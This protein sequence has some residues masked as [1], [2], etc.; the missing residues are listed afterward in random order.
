MYQTES[1]VEAFIGRVTGA[2]RSAL[3]LDF[4]GTLAPF[5]D[6]RTRATPY[7]E[8]LPVLSAL[9]TN[10]RTRLV[11][12]S[13]RAARDVRE[14][15]PLSP[16]PEIWGAHGFERLL[17]DGTLLAAK[18]DRRS[19][20]AIVEA[21]RW[22][23]AQGFSDRLE[24]K[25]GGVA[26]HWRGLPA[27]EMENM[28]HQGMSAFL[29]LTR[30]T[31]LSVGEFDG[32]IELRMRSRSKGYAVQQIIHEMG[33][34]PIAYLGDDRTDEDAFRVL[35][36]VGLTVLV[37]QELRS[38]AAEIWIRPPEQLVEFL[39]SWLKASGGTQ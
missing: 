39:E 16:T 29:P 17:P 38:T 15:L 19:A 36:G 18:I 35:R 10:P 11:L 14:R 25:A 28:Y 23:C 7:P 3:L 37:R 24:R 6:D 5:V 2:P 9:S 26:L 22:A 30:A 31:R 8:V 27:T 12:I 34:A 20:R 13:G 21:E 1:A 32:G 33:D 4:D